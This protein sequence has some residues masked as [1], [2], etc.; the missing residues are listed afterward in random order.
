M[1]EIP[2]IILYIGAPIIIGLFFVYNGAWI[3]DYIISYM[4][5]GSFRNCLPGKDEN[6]NFFQKI[7]FWLAIIAIFFNYTC[8]K[9]F[10]VFHSIVLG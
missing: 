8:Y 4:C 5:D 9:I 3:N 6:V 7:P 1:K 10:E 2:Y